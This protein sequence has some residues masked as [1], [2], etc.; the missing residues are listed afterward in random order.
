MSR[1]EKF[2]LTRWNRAGL[3]KFR[4]IDGN[5]IT[6]LETLRQQLVE[7]YDDGGTP[8]WS[9][10]VTRFPEISNETPL[11][12]RNRLTA[13]YNDERRDYAWEILRTFARSAHVLGEYIDA[14]ANEGYLSTAVEWDNVRKLV[15]MLGYRPAPPASSETHIALLFKE[16]QSGTLEKGFAVKNKPSGSD[17]TILF[18]TQE[19]LE[20]SDSLNILRP[21]QYDMNLNQFGLKNGKLRFPVS[22]AYE[23]LNVGD[24]GVLSTQSNGVPITLVEIR[25]TGNGVVLMLKPAGG[26]L[27][28]IDFRFHN[29]SL[30]LQPKFIAAPLPN[31]S[32]SAKV[33]ETLAI[34]EEQIAFV[35][36]G[37]TWK[38]MKI[39]RNESLHLLFDKT[40]DTLSKG[41]RLYSAG[42]LTRDMHS[43]LRSSSYI[44]L[45][46]EEFDDDFGWF[47]KADGQK[48]ADAG[49]I[50]SKTLD[51]VQFRFIQGNHGK[52][53]YYPA[54]E[55]DGR[56]EAVDISEFRFAGKTPKLESGGWAIAK[57]AG[58]SLQAVQISTITEKEKWFSLGLPG[59]STPLN[60]LRSGFAVSLRPRNH[61]L[62]S[63]FAWSGASSE[64]VTVIDIEDTSL[65][66]ALRL[67]QKLICSCGD[68]ALVVE[69][70]D[71][72][73][74]SGLLNLH[75]APA[76]HESE[77]AG[78]YTRSATKLYGNAVRATHGETQPEKIVGNG[79]ASQS[80]QAFLLPPEKISWIADS[81]FASGVKADL[82]L[83]VGQ[84]IWEQV[85]DLSGSS[86]TDHHYMVKVTQ[87]GRL[88]V[89]F[90][91][92][93]HGRRVPTGI[94][95]IRVRYRTGYGLEGNL[96]AG[97]LV[98]IVRPDD[99]IEDFVSPLPSSGGA[100][101]ES[102]DSM[103]E[104]APATLLALERAVSLDDYTHLAAHHSMVWQAQAFEILPNRP[105]R[106]EIRVVIVQAGGATFETDPK[107]KEPASG[108]AKMIRDYLLKHT[109]PNTPI[110]VVSYRPLK[111]ALKVEIM[112][113]PVAFDKKQVQ[114]AVVTH[115]EENLALNQRQLGQSLFRSEV[116]ALVEQVVGVENGHCDILATPYI[117][118]SE[119][120]KPVL[121]KGDDDKIIRVSINP[122][123]LL[124]LDTDAY[125]VVISARDYEI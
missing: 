54:L 51:G 4:Y 57:S 83:R 7:A 3:S 48:V 116:I 24:T 10:L 93:R 39:E 5:A 96:V 78:C 90:G 75:L 65:E 53:I 77:S 108:I 26:S 46:P 50:Q 44:Y 101:K 61:D 19:K 35:K 22:E 110:S 111:M 74:S 47:V 56:I 58:A 63:R 15:G 20:G 120:E 115:L 89:C 37:R 11:Q 80:S 45:L 52:H 34:A 87:E 94:D 67:G 9:E 30:H 73:T 14:Y 119:Q 62:N 92:G 118:M 25:E 6:Y 28:G 49:D 23:E 125:Q 79:D 60:L 84:R 32:K 69:L 95:N 8:T 13:Q 100:E 55:Q 12:T 81:Q 21:Y 41:D 88:E 17:P 82:T 29:T 97:E 66:E 114:Q 68:N 105:A 33:D 124:Y 85:E 36:S 38:A 99:L 76:F 122:D 112:V 64:T 18:E 27:G 103:R 123:Q 86:P 98:K 40:A 113:D 107:A 104:K 71:V 106:P 70:K 121:H 31:G 2:D 42:T 59:V 72:R 117:G 91:D 43:K 1:N 102:A 16:S 109:I